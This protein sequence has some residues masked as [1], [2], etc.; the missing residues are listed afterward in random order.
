M[1]LGFMIVLKRAA[2]KREER[3]IVIDASF[4][5]RNIRHLIHNQLVYQAFL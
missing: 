3:S 2:I 5:V 1:N 4:H